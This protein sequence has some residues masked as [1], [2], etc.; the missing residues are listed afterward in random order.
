[1]ET[2]GPPVVR[3]REQVE[4]GEGGGSIGRIFTCLTHMH[5]TLCTTVIRVNVYVPL[6]FVIC[7]A[8]LLNGLR[9]QSMIDPLRRDAS[10]LNVE[11]ILLRR[12]FSSGLTLLTSTCTPGLG[13][14]RVKFSGNGCI[15]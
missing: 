11:V 5:H 1:M 9:L 2:S 3:I 14:I 4:E 12:L 7:I 15:L 10:P 13:L 6:I 8:S